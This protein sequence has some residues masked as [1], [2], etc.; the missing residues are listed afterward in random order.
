ME[1]KVP[2]ADQETSRIDLLTV[3]SIAV[4]S[5]LTGV[6]AHEALG[7][8]LVALLVGLHPQRVT[9]VEL[10]VSF[11]GVPYW[12]VRAVA[13]AG[14]VGNLIISALSLIL[15]RLLRGASATTRYFLWL[16]SIINLFAPGGYLLILSFTSI[17]DWNLF[18]QELPNEFAWRMGLT[19]LGAIISLT[20]VYLGVRN[21]DPFLGYGN[22]PRHRRAT[23]LT[24]IPYITGGI[25]STLASIF[26]PA[27]PSLILISAVASSFGGTI[28]LIWIN[29][30]VG[31]PI[32]ATAEDVPLTPERSLLW[33]I[34]GLVALVIY[35]VALGPGLPR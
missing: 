7:H 29:Q 16:T 27:G 18:V 2:L 35:F 1:E 19:I 15:M 32:K 13:A 5:Y 28:F 21:L 34:L 17:G 8:G 3:A 6:I 22:K 24:F 23:K 26:N 20:G 10:Q 12:K 9:S 11:T 14:C 33:I 30:F 25:V 31:R 4:V